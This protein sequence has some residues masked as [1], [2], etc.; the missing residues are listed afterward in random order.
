MVKRILSELIKS[1]LDFKKIVLLIGARQVGKSSLIKEILKEK[2]V[3]YL[4]INGDDPFQRSIFSNPTFEFIKEYIKEYEYIFF[5]E[6]QRFENIGITLKLI[7]DN[8]PNKQVIVSG[9]SS[10]ELTDKINEPLTG[11]KWEYNLFP[12]SWNEIKNEIGFANS[13]K[14]LEKYL[15]YGMYPEVVINMEN[16][17]KEILIQLS[18][19]YLYKDILELI[20]I[21]KPELL[22]KILQ[23]LAFQVGSEVSYNELANLCNADRNTIINYIH[24]LEKSFVIYRLEPF[25]K[26]KRKEISTSRKIYFYDN[27]IRNALINNFKTIQLRDDIGKLWENFIITERFKKHKNENELYNLYFWR[28]KQDAEIDLIEEKDGEISAFEIKWNDK[29]KVHFSKTFTNEYHPKS[30]E[31]I[32]KENFYNYL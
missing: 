22:L 6:A 16:N 25:S 30:T 27:G 14:N 13:L 20:N 8:I 12:F 15:V 26:N 17:P 1:K 32:N 11:R 2:K 18:G 4:F 28:S 31:V 9:S 5:D 3:D 7:I 10:L 24:L 29:K 21:K 19:S 23:A